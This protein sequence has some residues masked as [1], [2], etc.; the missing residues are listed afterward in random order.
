MPASS[1]NVFS[2]STAAIPPP[3]MAISTTTNGA[4]FRAEATGLPG[5]TIRV[6]DIFARRFCRLAYARRDEAVLG[7]GAAGSVAA[8]PVTALCR[9]PPGALSPEGLSRVCS[10]VTMPPP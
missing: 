3:R 4:R 1:V 8:A 6:A 5:V 2:H 7:A 9:L 10:V